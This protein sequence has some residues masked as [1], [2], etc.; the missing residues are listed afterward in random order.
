MIVM[1]AHDCCIL[2]ASK[3]SQA[4]GKKEKEKVLKMH[5]IWSEIQ[6]ATGKTNNKTQTRKTRS[7]LARRLIGF[8]WLGCRP[9]KPSLIPRTHIK[10]K[11]E[12]ALQELSSDF[13]MCVTAYR[14]NVK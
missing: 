3:S 12:D 11:G 4:K 6:L 7:G 9:G 2:S 1:Q 8:R 13:H 5:E 14:L 10:V